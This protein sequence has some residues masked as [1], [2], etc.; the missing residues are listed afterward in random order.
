MILPDVNLLIYAHNE[1]DV[2]FPMAK[3]WFEDLLNSDK[4]ACFC[5]ETLNGFLR[6][7][8]NPAA[9]PKPLSL[10]QAFDK[11][12]GWME[13]PAFV[14]LTPR[15]DHIDTL[16]RTA[17]DAEAA[18][19]RFSDAVLAAYAISYNISFASTDRHFRMFSKLKLI[20]PLSDH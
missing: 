19:K 9:M 7:S 13:Q 2:R 11:V 10:A 4:S 14:L 15:P 8:T 6:I 18:G 16:R 12:Q 3:Q 1:A 5:W 17:I 20:D